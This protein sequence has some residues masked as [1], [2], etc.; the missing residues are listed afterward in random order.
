MWEQVQGV[1]SDGG[2]FSGPFG[3]PHSNVWVLSETAGYFLSSMATRGWY[4]LCGDHSSPTCCPICPLAQSENRM[5]WLWASPSP[6]P[7]NKQNMGH[8][9]L[10]KAL[11]GTQSILSKLNCDSE[12]FLG[13]ELALWRVSRRLVAHQSKKRGFGICF[14]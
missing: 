5:G 9:G 2:T 14:D 1:F 6:R 4:T 7:S 11:G 3:I 8:P 12:G 10:N 13:G